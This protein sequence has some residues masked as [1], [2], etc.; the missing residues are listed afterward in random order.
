MDQ[1][2]SFDPMVALSYAAAVTQRIRLGVAVVVLPV[3]SPIHVAHA[4]ASLDYL[5]GGRAMLGVGLG[6]EHYAAFN[7][8]ATRRAQRFME[9]VEL[10]KALW[11]QT[12]VVYEGQFFH[13]EGSI[14]LKPV[15]QPHPPI[16]LGGAHP[17]ALRRA[18]AVGDGWIGA[19]GQSLASFRNC[20]A[21][22][23]PALAERGRSPS[24]YP[25]SKRVFV[26]VD[27]RP[28]RARS[29]V[30]RWFTEV[31][32]N[33]AQTDA[34]GIHGTPEQVREGIEELVAVGAN[35]LL[36]NPIARYEEQVEALASVVGLAD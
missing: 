33:P 10:L 6:R 18:A 31:Y 29:E 15:Q 1:V 28:E 20:V 9:E 23:R 5:S 13:V 8:P 30:Y 35:Y 22:L 19:G 16:W 3:R 14:A 34:S 4:V 12:H 26:H 7:V 36:L 24:D 25:I 17:E 11:T 27:E 21:L 2:Y 32:H